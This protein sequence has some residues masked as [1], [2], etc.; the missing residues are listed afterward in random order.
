MSPCH[1]QSESPPHPHTPTPH[2]SPTSPGRV[3]TDGRG[4]NH[5]LTDQQRRLADLLTRGLTLEEAAEM[6]FISRNTA[7]SHLK[8]VYERLGVHNRAQLVRVLTSNQSAPNH[9][10]G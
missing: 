7:K 4:L 6:L 1:S 8:V 2:T 9:P 3:P 5:A 10:N